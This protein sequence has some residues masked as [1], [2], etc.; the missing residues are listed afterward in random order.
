MLPTRQQEIGN[1]N[2]LKIMLPSSDFLS[3][4]LILSIS[5]VICDTMAVPDNNTENWQLMLVHTNDMHSRFAEVDKYLNPCGK[6][7]ICYGGFARMKTALE[8]AFKEASEI[9]MP[10]ISLNAGDTFQGSTFFTILGWKLV[11]EMLQHLRID[12]MCLGNHEFDSGVDNLYEFL[13]TV[14]IPVVSS[15]LD[16]SKESKMANSN[17]VTKSKVLIVDGKKIGIIGYLIPSTKLRSRT[18]NIIF[19]P[20]IPSV[21]AEAKRLKNEGVDIL[22]GLGHSG[23]DV[24][25]E[26]AKH[27]KELDLIVGGHSNTFLYNDQPPDIEVPVDTYPY[28]VEQPETRKRIP[29]VQ[30]YKGTK[31]MGKLKIKFNKKGELVKC[32]GNPILLD[33]KIKPDPDLLRRIQ[34]VQTQIFGKINE[35]VAV[36]GVF[37]EGDNDMCRLR[38]CNVGNL[39]ADAFVEYNLKKYIGTFNF[40]KQWTD[41]SIAI[42][43]SGSMRA[44]IDTSMNEGN[45][46][47][48]DMLRIFPFT[49]D[50]GKI[51]VKGSAIWS[52]FE[53]SVRR[54]EDNVKY[55]DFLQVSGL[56]V[57]IDVSKPLG[58]RVQSIYV[59]CSICR[60]PIY[61]PIV[62]ENVY[63]V[64]MTE[65]L[66]SGGD[67]YN[68][69]KEDSEFHRIGGTE[70]SVIEYILSLKSPLY[71]GIEGRVIVIRSVKS[72]SKNATPKVYSTPTIIAVFIIAL[73]AFN[74]Y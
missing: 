24:D 38:E 9:T 16:F 23:F 62:M 7:E 27:V 57:V 39:A 5:I 8:A 45:L 32:E 47:K 37:L 22:I 60:V 35:F 20:E 34:V 33:S 11:V 51:Q 21:S 58:K 25:K 44:S 55:G 28:W 2:K 15:N 6:N 54:Y 29:I 43:Q 61:E 68:M 26:V 67:E 14:N 49:S 63:N 18:G 74:L 41:A 48:G 17:L 4:F 13:K 65:Y 69:F 12:V 30:A 64:I 40:T 71:Q 73:Y 19:L 56:K 50:V 31:Y 42:L 53:H 1:F 72:T 66:A 52:A 46:T 59:R 36:S 70:E 3:L 10:F